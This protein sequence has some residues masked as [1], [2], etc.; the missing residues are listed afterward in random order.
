MV[1][2]RG[3]RSRSAEGLRGGLSPLTSP[4]S[5]NSHGRNPLA[6]LAPVFGS[7]H[8]LFSKVRPSDNV[9]RMGSKRKVKF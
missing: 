2:R 3:R 4:E 7:S 9:H 8:M 1:M 6:G 5:A